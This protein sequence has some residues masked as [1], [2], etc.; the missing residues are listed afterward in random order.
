MLDS[1]L[2]SSFDLYDTQHAIVGWLRVF[3]EVLTA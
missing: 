2:G 3:I 1:Q